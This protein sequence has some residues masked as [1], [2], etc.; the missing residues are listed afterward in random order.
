MQLILSLAYG[1]NTHTEV[2]HGSHTHSLSWTSG[3]MT[4]DQLAGG[5]RAVFVP[6]GR[7]LYGGAAHSYTHCNVHIPPH[8]HPYRRGSARHG[9]HAG[10]QHLDGAVLRDYAHQSS[11]G[12]R[13]D[14]GDPFHTYF[15]S[16]RF[17]TT[18]HDERVI[19]RLPLL[20]KLSLNEV[21]V[22]SVL[23]SNEHHFLRGADALHEATVEDEALQVANSFEA[24]D[25][26]Q[27]IHVPQ[28]L[29]RVYLCGI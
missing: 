12:V 17:H 5:T 20:A 19:L 11:F 6:E 9:S 21:V 4:D 10:K 18:Q 27:R 13:G 24:L 29:G 2:A 23:V 8:I 22:P 28:S 1:P 3:E 7:G 15:L 16:W 26:G 14:V 25:C